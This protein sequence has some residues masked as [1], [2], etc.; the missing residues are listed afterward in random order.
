MK[1][2]KR[3]QAPFCFLISPHMLIICE[4]SPITLAKSLSAAL[5]SAGR[6]PGTPLIAGG[7][8][9]RRKSLGDSKR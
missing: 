4:I 5:N 6:I 7:H 1:C 2:T 3:H 8:R 9:P